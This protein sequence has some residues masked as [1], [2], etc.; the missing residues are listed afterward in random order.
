M[1]GLFK[2]T[3]LVWVKRVLG[4]ERPQPQLQIGKVSTGKEARCPSCWWLISDLA[5]KNTERLKVGFVRYFRGEMGKG[6]FL[7][8]FLFGGLKSLHRLGIVF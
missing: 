4:T 2:G 1:L 6:P 3:P 5:G 7:F 8:V